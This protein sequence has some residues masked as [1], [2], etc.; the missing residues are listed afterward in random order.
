MPNWCSNTVT[1]WHSDPKMITRAVRAYT[2]QKLFHEFV[3]VPDALSGTTAGHFSDPA[4]QAEL[5]A[6]N[7]HNLATYGYQNWYDFCRHEWGTKWDVGDSK[8]N[9]TKNSKNEVRFYFDSAWA[10]PI[11][12]YRKMEELG[13]MIDAFYY[14]PGVMFCGRFSEGYDD[15]YGLADM[16]T[17]EIRSVLPKEIDEEFNIIDSI[18]DMREEEE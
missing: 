9:V 1:L 16:T 8:D 5:N 14:E 4:R 6:L 18:R 13:F 12:F 10:P 15:Y 17:E 3:P 2:K 11:A 7:E